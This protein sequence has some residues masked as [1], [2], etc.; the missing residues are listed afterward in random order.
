MGQPVYHPIS[1]GNIEFHRF[2]CP[3]VAPAKVTGWPGENGNRFLPGCSEGQ[4]MAKRALND[5]II[6]AAKPAAKGRR[7]EIWDSVT[8]GVGIRTTDTGKK[9][10]VLLARY[11]G[12]N[13]N[14]KTGI[15]NPT[16]R[17]LGEYGE[18][19]LAEA[20]E[21]ARHWLALIKEG[22]DPRD[23]EESKRR[24]EIR[25]R[26]NTFAAVA[27]DFITEKLSTERKEER[28]RARHPTRSDSRA[29]AP[30]DSQDFRSRYPADHQGQETACAGAGAQPSRHREPI[31]RL[32][33]PAAGE[34]DRG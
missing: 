22:K 1:R 7:N 27:E 12:S 17:A 16:R 8:P 28:G 26:K 15:P 21:K 3:S 18:I 33:R 25:Q 13:E 14:P 31:V 5:R 9:T 34:A 32:G 20:R 6:R 4:D 19:G 30:S 24:T 2:V 11:P 29:W 10:F 23:E